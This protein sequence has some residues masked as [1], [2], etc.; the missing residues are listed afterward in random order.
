VCEGRVYF[1]GEDGYLYILGSG[2]QAAP[3]T[4][5]RK[6]DQI[7][8]PVPEETAEADSN[9]FTSFGN[10]ANTNATRQKVKPPLQLQWIRRFEGT[11]KHLSVCGGGR[12]YTHT[13]E[14]QIFAVEQETGRLLWRRYF[15]G[16]HV[17]YT[18]PL[19]YRGKLLVPQAGLKSC[20]LRCLDAATGRLLWE[21][22]FSG[23]PS[24]NRQLPP[25]VYKNRVIY[26]F[27]TGRYRPENWLF[28]HQSTFGFPEDQKPL[29][30]AWDL[31]SGREV[32]TRDFSQYGSGGDDAGM[33]LADG[34]LYYSC[35]FGRKP[36]PG[37]TAAMN[38]ENGEI[39][40]I[41]TEHAVHAGC[42]IS[43]REGR[44]YL[45]GYNAV[46]GDRNVVW[47]LDARDGSLIWKSDPL[48][49]AIHVVTVTDKFLFTHAQYRNGYLLDKE[50]GKIITTLAKGYRCS[51]FTCCEPY[52]IG[53]NFDVFELSDTPSLISSGP[54]LDVLMCVGAFAS[55]GR[56]FL[57][58][59]G[60]GLQACMAPIE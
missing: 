16:V 37:V 49:G 21:V 44:L 39:N 42:T 2:G 27:S 6:L 35:Y 24:W 51:R 47:C 55:G 18:S 1:A 15:P 10:W 46:D 41:S 12:M 43:A 22:P 26:Q 17:S 56:L 30:R 29:V 40:W 57:T 33:C 3:P 7:R 53:P 28:E 4:E 31:D 34:V 5:D 20:M 19:Y 60:S 25:I 8:S 48:L 13:A 58:T 36:V 32:W 54:Q 23:S 45:G 52:L 11:V 59:N 9:W 14:G 38:P 50:T